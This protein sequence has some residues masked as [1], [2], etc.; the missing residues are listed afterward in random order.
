M[1]AFLTVCQIPQSNGKVTG[2][3]ARTTISQLLGAGPSAPIL[4]TTL[5]LAF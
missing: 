3:Q 1:A 5:T 4:F 2:S